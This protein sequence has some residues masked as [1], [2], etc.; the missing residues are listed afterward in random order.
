MIISIIKVIIKIIHNE[1][2]Q[3]VFINIIEISLLMKIRL[4]N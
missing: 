1:L 4:K 3:F 2:I